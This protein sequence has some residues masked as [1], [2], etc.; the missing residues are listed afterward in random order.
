MEITY[1]CGHCKSVN[2]VKLD[3]IDI[4]DKTIAYDIDRSIENDSVSRY[5]GQNIMCYYC[6][7][8]NE[9][10]NKESLITEIKQEDFNKFEDEK[11]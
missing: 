5:L 11:I 4:S 2:V 7:D 9:T 8:C 1:K 3:W 10:F 6:Q